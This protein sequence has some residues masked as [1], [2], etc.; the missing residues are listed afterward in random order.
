[1]QPGETLSVKVL[2]NSGRLLKSFALVTLY[3]QFIVPT[4]DL[5]SGVYYISLEVGGVVQKTAKLVLAK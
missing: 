3:D 2:D 5:S 1:M 4:N